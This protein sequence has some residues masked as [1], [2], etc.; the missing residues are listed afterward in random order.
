M[1]GIYIHIPFCTQR[2]LY[3]DFY[4]NTEMQHKDDFCQALMREIVLRKD[5]LGGEPIETLY[6]GGGTPSQL[7]AETYQQLLEV[8]DKYHSLSN[9]KE[10][11]LEANPDDLSPSYIHTLRTLPFNRISMG[12]QSFDDSDLHFLRRRHDAAQAIKAVRDCQDAGFTNL[13]IDLIYGLPHQTL[14]AWDKNLSQ[15]L[16]LNVPHLSAYHLTYE[17]GTALYRLWQSGKVKQV[18]EDLSEHLFIQL[19]QRLKDAAYEHY[20]ISNFAKEGK[21]AQHNTAYW[22]E[23]K[24]M[25]LGPSSHSFDI[26]SRQW[27]VSSLK[28]YIAALRENTPLFERET[29]TLDMRYNEYI[30]TSLRT[31]W[32]ISLSHITTSYGEKYKEH[33][34]HQATPFMEQGSLIREADTLCLSATK[35]IF[36]SDGIMAALMYD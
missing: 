3:C 29:R 12:V 33:L 1:A 20:E 35:G 13:S 4:S 15:A 9:C 21:Y 22:Q 31:M 26:E 10:I 2:C 32:G 19:I 6:I 16:A 23:K 27:N 11:T 7:P 28:E 17:E 36:I 24:Y 34:L 18:D 25:G 8:V 30:L 14:E 5:Y